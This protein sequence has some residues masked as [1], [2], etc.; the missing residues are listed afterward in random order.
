V[1]DEGLQG[2]P[3][4][5]IVAGEMK[6]E[7]L[8]KIQHVLERRITNEK[9]VVYLLV[10]LR[11]LMDRDDYKDPVLRTFS[12]WV[13]H[14]SLENR[15]EGSTF[16]LSQFDHF[17]GELIEHKRK[18]P[19]LQQISLGAFR[20]TLIR[21]FKHFNLSATFTN[22]LIEW[23]K[24]A[25]MYC[26][27]VSECPIVFTASKTKLKYIRQVELRS[28]ARD[29]LFKEW[30]MVQWRLTFHDGTTENWSFLMG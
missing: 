1:F 24:F 25:T 20:K 6:D 16:I 18:S 13:V 30:P 26:L 8:R 3:R 12:N 21:C 11:K 19:H 17:M 7:L 5:A 29:L 9:Q 4:F 23:K 28:I 15:A 27:V 10:E 14:T 22:N 2:T